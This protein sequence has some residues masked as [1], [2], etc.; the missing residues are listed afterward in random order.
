[1]D[2]SE[3]AKKRILILE[4]DKNCYARIK[5]QF[6]TVGASTI[7]VTTTDQALD[8]MS[9]MAADHLVIDLDLNSK[10]I[11][12]FLLQGQNFLSKNPN[13]IIDRKLLSVDTSIIKAQED[14]PIIKELFYKDEE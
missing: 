12:E 9:V 7:K 4:R 8:L 10:Y 2:L 5:H 13:F 3:Y 6:E 14:S 11:R 1:M